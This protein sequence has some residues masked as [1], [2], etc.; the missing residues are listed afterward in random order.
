MSPSRLNF[1]EV[2]DFPVMS[3]NSTVRDC[4]IQMNAKNCGFCALVEESGKMVGLFTDGD[5]RRVITNMDVNFSALMV[6]DA[7]RI[8][9]DKFLYTKSDDVSE[10][11]KL[12]SDN[13]VNEI[14]KLNE[15][16]MIVGLYRV[17]KIRK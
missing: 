13:N 10:I 1:Y 2:D 12:I 4:L 6:A 3:I 9:K 5:F 8:V 16:Q 7:R 17:M 15:Q 11:A 14:P